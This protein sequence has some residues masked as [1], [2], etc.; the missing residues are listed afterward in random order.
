MLL[1][2]KERF[3]DPILDDTKIFTVRD[4]RKITPKPG[5]TIYM[6]SALRTKHTKFITDRFKYNGKQKVFLMIYRRNGKISITLRVDGRKL[7]LREKGLF[8]I[9]DGFIDQNDFA[10]YWINSH[11]APKKAP[12]NCCLKGSKTIYHWTPFR[13]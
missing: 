1:G 5:E 13:F 8:V 3:A 9:F 2:F 4:E 11:Y 6:Y 7:T 10:D 12:A